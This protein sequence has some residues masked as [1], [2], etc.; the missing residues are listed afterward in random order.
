LDNVKIKIEKKSENN[1]DPSYSMI[2]TADG[3]VQYNGVRNVKAQG[4]RV[5][6]ISQADVLEMVDR[7]KMIYFFSLKD[8][9]VSDNQNEP[10]TIVSIQVNDKFKQI[11]FSKYSRAPHSL[12]NLISQIQMITKT[13]ELIE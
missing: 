9:Y 2:I 5:V 12:N 1:I 8:K 13:R 4:H 7:F 6:Q 11:E 10:M 3:K